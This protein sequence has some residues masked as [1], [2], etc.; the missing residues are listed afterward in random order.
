MSEIRRIESEVPAADRDS[1]AEALLVEGLDKYFAGRYEEAIHVWTRV[2]FLDRNHARARAYID[3]ARTALGEQ[4]RRGDEMLH[5]AEGLVATG[6]LDR[7]RSLLTQASRAAGDEDRVAR[8]W[9]DIDRVER[10]R[11]TRSQPAARVAVVD[12]KPVGRWRIGARLA[13]QLLAAAAVGAL[14]VTLATSLVVRDWVTGAAGPVGAATLGHPAFPAVPSRSEV[15]LVRARTLYAHGRL[16]EALQA[17]DAIAPSDPKRAEVDALRVEIQE[18]LL[19]TI[20]ATST[21]PPMAGQ[22]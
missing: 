8:L 17:L 14:C 6:E 2:L 4:Q 22:P 10:S 11:V 5:A 1:R 15:A 7:A 12:V 13:W 20:P 3:R 18:V 16:A 19:S 21:A 9:T